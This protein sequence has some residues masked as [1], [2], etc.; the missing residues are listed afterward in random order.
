MP[1]QQKLDL[2]EKDPPQNTRKRRTILTPSEYFRLIG[3]VEREYAAS[4]LTDVAFAQTAA[5]AL[6]IPEVNKNHVETAREHWKL[7]SNRDAAREEKRK[8]PQAEDLTALESR[9][10]SLEKQVRK[11]FAQQDALENLKE[12]DIPS[13][14]DLERFAK[15]YYGETH[16]TLSTK[17][18]LL[19]A[20][21]VLREFS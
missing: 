15:H 10:L 3:Y 11:L 7:P 6:G 16:G 17:A 12:R 20:R 21:A 13:D 5:L 14:E 4:K 2:I 9:V 8:G 1:E 18:N 19:F